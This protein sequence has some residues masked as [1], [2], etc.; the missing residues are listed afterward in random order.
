MLGS[1]LLQYGEEDFSDEEV[2]EQ[3]KPASRKAYNKCWK[4][5]KEIQK[6]MPWLAQSLCL[7]APV[8]VQERI[9][10]TI[11]QALSS[12]PTLNGAN[13]N[14]KIV[15]LNDNSGNLTF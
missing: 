9:E 8:P 15:V 4:E 10:S 3:I 6:C 1:L 5:F 13:V 12:V 7:C 11:M 14:V 2:F